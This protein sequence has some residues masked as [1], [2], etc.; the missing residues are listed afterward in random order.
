MTKFNI[1]LKILF[2]FCE[3]IGLELNKLAEN[4][5]EFWVFYIRDWICLAVSSV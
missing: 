5:E 1:L 2:N 4:P 3:L